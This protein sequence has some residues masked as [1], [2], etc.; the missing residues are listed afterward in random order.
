MTT[1]A[2]VASE[3]PVTSMDTVSTMH[4]ISYNLGSRWGEGF[5]VSLTGIVAA[6]LLVG[7]LGL[8]SRA[9]DGRDVAAG[10][11]VAVGRGHGRHFGQM[12]VKVL[13]LLPLPLH[14]LAL[15]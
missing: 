4:P 5:G 7:A 6:N 1:M 15:L 3:G 13:L 9:D 2:L 11:A 8:V 12:G 14:R 10:L